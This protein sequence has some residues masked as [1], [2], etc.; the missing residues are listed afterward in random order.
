MERR[1][2]LVLST[3]AEAHLAD[4]TPDVDVSEATR[5]ASEVL[6]LAAQTS[7]QRGLDAVARV[8]RRLAN[9]HSQHPDAQAFEHRGDNCSPPPSDIEDVAH[10]RPRSGH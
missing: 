8:R 7:S 1:R 6:D 9:K 10:R 4:S 3:V 5:V 2:I